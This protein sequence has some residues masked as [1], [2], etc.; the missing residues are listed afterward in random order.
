MYVH[1]LSIPYTYQLFI[2][3]TYTH[4]CDATIKG[5]IVDYFVFVFRKKKTNFFERKFYAYLH[6]VAD[7]V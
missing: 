2:L 6:E 7:V 4:Q 5:I 3:H 1:H